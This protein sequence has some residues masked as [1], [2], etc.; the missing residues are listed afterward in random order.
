VL[1]VHDSVVWLLAVVHRI[2]GLSCVKTV[3]KHESVSINFPAALSRHIGTVLI[4]EVHASDNTI[5]V[6]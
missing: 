1:L 4:Y 3:E 5:A 6:M 2:C